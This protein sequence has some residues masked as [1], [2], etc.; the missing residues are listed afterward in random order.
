MVFQETQFGRPP[1][2]LEIEYAR[3]HAYVGLEKKT[4]EGIRK[5][6]KTKGRAGDLDEEE[7]ADTE[8]STSVSTE[9]R[10]NS[11]DATSEGTSSASSTSS[12][13]EDST[14]NDDSASESDDE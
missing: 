13:G 12:S 11:D 14:E 8:R 2:S 9:S 4:K 10:G 7:S 1:T 6:K 3:T 5:L